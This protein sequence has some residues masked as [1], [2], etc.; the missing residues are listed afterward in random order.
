MTCASHSGLPTFNRLNSVFI[1]NKIS[2]TSEM[3]FPGHPIIEYN[4]NKITICWRKAYYNIE[5]G[6]KRDSQVS[7]LILLFH[8]CLRK[9]WGP[10]LS[11]ARWFVDVFCLV[12]LSHFRICFILLSVRRCVCM[13][14]ACVSLPCL[15][16]RTEQKSLCSHS[17]H[18]QVINLF[19][20]VFC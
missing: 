9:V 18:F 6:R 2:Q 17:L 14:V 10:V 4:Y 13:G 16:D 11:L 19:G 20:D 12:R 3:Y 15:H 8:S 5:I 1:I 7:V